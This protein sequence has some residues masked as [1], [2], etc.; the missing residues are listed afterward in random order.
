MKN[1]YKVY[2]STL[3]KNNLDDIINDC[4]FMNKK[5]KHYF[6]HTNPTSSTNKNEFK[7]FKLHEGYKLYNIFGLSSPNINFYN[8][9]K[10]LLTVINEFTSLNEFYIQSWLNYQDYENVL[11]W[12]THE[13]YDFHGYI[14]I[15]PKDTI[16]EFEDYIIENQSGLIYIGEGNPKHRVVNKSKYSGNRITIGFDIIKPSNNFVKNRGFIPVFIS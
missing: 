7:E 6:P 8:I 2:D 10:E 14:C 9:Y 3:I 5:I 16:T 15:D 4:S 11:D 1:K 13:G 12:H